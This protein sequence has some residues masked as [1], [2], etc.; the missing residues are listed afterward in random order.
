MKIPTITINRKETKF[1]W[2]VELFFSIEPDFQGQQCQNK[3]LWLSDLLTAD[4]SIKI[5]AKVLSSIE[6]GG[7]WG[8]P[9]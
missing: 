1:G 5:S 6:L 9:R 2:Y 8:V 7:D 3:R 4:E